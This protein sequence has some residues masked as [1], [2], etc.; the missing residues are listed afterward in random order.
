VAWRDVRPEHV[1]AAIA[2]YDRLGQEEFLRT[3]RFGPARDYV[4]VHDGKRYDSKAIVG[5]AHKFLAGQA[6]AAS[7]F[8]GGDA[9]VGRLLRDLGFTVQVGAN[10]D[11]DKLT[12]LLAKLD[13]NQRNGVPALYQP[14]MLLW[15]FGRARQGMPRMTSWDETGRTLH[16][17]FAR[18]GRPGEERGRAAYPAA[19]LHR[20]GL[21]ELD[22]DGAEPSGAHSSM[23]ESWFRAHQ[24]HGGLA[25]PVHD[26]VRDSAAAR[27]AAAETLLTTYFAGVEYAELLEEV[28]LL[29]AG[30][31][32]PGDS[33]LPYSPLET[34][35]AQLCAIARRGRNAHGGER[36]ERNVQSPVRSACARRAVLIR[37]G[38]HCENPNCSGDVRD[39]TRNGDPI[40]EI[41]HVQ[42]LADG[43]SDDPVNMI[44]LCPN[45]HAIKTR[46]A[47]AGQLRPVLLETAKRR[48]E[49]L[50][51]S[52]G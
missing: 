4:L 36:A 47:T 50:L 11:A 38:G 23:T 27:F 43:G 49:R 10:L 13:V 24:P 7:E 2:E 8:S 32:V 5:V 17:L 52:Q 30:F 33:L 26:L 25:V 48:H 1:L 31:P 22:A 45:C 28:G 42:D 14:I 18:F 20:A 46:G 35:Y 19:A 6:L 51:G 39:R 34:A 44:A 3:Y 16:D 12:E 37:S 9:T 40:L 15:A 29:D 41:D 21:W